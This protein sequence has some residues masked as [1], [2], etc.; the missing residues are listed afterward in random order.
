M[1][2]SL[3]FFVAAHADITERCCS[4]EVVGHTE[5]RRSAMSSVISH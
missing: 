1:V 5:R 3:T 4:N 2:K